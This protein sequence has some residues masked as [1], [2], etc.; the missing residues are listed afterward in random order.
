MWNWEVDSLHALFFCFILTEKFD[1]QHWLKSN[2]VPHAYCHIFVSNKGDLV[3][4]IE[5]LG[6]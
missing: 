2:P 6:A 4:T 3:L 1:W 5:K